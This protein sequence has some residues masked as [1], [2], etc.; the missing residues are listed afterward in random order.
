MLSSCVL[1]DVEGFSVVVYSGFGVQTRGLFGMATDQMA[2]MFGQL[3]Q[4]SQQLLNVSRVL[5]KLGLGQI[6]SADY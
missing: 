3:Q 5:S 2:Q 6:R 4:L 1:V